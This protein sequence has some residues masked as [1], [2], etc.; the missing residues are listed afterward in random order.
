MN[1]HECGAGS[2]GEGEWVMLLADLQQPWE[3]VSVMELGRGPESQTDF[4]G[5]LFRS[6]TQRGGK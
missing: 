6:R 5:Q 2:L 3:A 4:T 1:I